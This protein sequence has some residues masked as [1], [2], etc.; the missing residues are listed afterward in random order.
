MREKGW[1]YLIVA[2]LATAS[3]EFIFH[4]LLGRGCCSTLLAMYLAPDRG[5]K[6]FWGG[7]VDNVAP[8]IFLGCING[9]VGFPKWSNRTLLITTIGIAIFVVGMIPVY[10]RLIGPKNFATVWGSTQVS[11]LVFRFLSAFVAAGFFTRAVYVMRRDW[12]K[13]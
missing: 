6:H 9:L 5:G 3:G 12:R 10:G 4:W 11:S 8:A 7:I 2:I 13:T 1:L